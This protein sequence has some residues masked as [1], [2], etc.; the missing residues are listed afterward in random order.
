MNRDYEIIESLNKIE[1]LIM[2]F[3]NQAS[4]SPKHPVLISEWMTLANGAKYAGVSYNSFVKFQRMGLKVS[5]VEGIK[6]V[7]RKEIDNFLENYSF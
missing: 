5:Q 2:S 4:Q 6:R 1:E 3:A 7:S